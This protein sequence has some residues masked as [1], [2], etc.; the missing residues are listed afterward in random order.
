MNKDKLKLL[1]FELLLHLIDG[2]IVYVLLSNAIALPYAIGLA[3]L[4]WFNE[5]INASERELL[6]NR[7][8]KLEKH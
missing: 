3:L 4:Y 2:I 6:K 1:P 7:I 8:D 5:S